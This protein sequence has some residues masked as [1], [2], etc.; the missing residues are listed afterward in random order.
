MLPALRNFPGCRFA[1][2]TENAM[3]E[4]ILLSVTLWESKAAADAYEASGLFASFLKKAEPTFAGLYRWKMALEHEERARMV[5]SED[6]SLDEYSVV[7]GKSF[8]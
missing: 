4:Q 5:T 6:I 2:M 1:F 8:S 3:D 7:T